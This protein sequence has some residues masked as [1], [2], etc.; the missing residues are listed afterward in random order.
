MK[1]KKEEHIEIEIW[2]V[3]IDPN[4]KIIIPPIVDK[5]KERRMIE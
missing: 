3:N 2:I 4:K 1:N 5:S